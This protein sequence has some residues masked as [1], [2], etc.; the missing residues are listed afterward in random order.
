[1]GTGSC[2]LSGREQ[3]P[4]PLRTY[5]CVGPQEGSDMSTGVANVCAGG[6]CCDFPNSLQILI[7]LRPQNNPVESVLSPIL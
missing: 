4:L 3:G 6:I 1:M 5:G 2:E 7:L